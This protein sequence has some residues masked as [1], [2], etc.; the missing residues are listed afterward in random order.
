M[1][2]WKVNGLKRMTRKKFLLDNSPTNLK[3]TM[4]D[5]NRTSMKNTTTDNNRTSTKNRKIRLHL[6]MAGCG[7]GSR[8]KCEE[9]IKEKKVKVNGRIICTLG[10][11]VAR[12]DIVEY[13]NQRIMPCKEKI[14]IALNKPVRYICSNSDNLDRPLAKE[15]FTS[16][17]KQRLFHV[18]RLDF[19]SSGLIFF[20]NDGIFANHITHPS[21]E[22]EKEYMV[23]ARKKISE[24]ILQKYRKGIRIDENLYTLKAFQHL[25]PYKVKLI[26]IEGKNR[27]IRRVFE[28]FK[29]PVKSIHRIRI[30]VVRIKSLKPGQFRHLSPK[31][32]NWFFR[33]H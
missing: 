23:A 4:T 25:T 7:I 6:F 9:Y 30:G 1:K 15:L 26:I 16:E 3:N 8:R 10:Y 17:I 5:K 12:N 2:S 14:Y 11:K 27:E 29:I 24:S 13:N 28:F 21:F 33:S 22:I 19:L 18:G 20:T 32:V 31:E